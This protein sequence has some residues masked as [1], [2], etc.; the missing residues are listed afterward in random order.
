MIAIYKSLHRHVKKIKET[1][2][3]RR[4]IFDGRTKKWQE[5]DR[6]E[7]HYSDTETLEEIQ[8]SLEDCI[9]DFEEINP[10]YKKPKE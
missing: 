3:I 9:D 7:I 5:S 1:V 2:K 8:S 6:G 4:E 10:E